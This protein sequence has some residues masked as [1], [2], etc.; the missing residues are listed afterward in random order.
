MRRFELLLWLKFLTMF[1]LEASITFHMPYFWTSWQ[2]RNW[3]WG[4]SLRT[5]VNW[6]CQCLN[7]DSQRKTFFSVNYLSLDRR[8]WHHVF[9]HYLK[10][11]LIITCL[12]WSFLIIKQ[13]GMNLNF[14][15]FTYKTQH[16]MFVHSCVWRHLLRDT[17][18]RNF[19]S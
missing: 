14:Q 11:S 4:Y 16:I 18:I 19:I 2:C 5:E 13:N 17:I 9:S 15:K 7:C 3:R 6:S 8:R 1:F 10:G 12:I